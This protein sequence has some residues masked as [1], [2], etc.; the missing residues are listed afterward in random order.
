MIVHP[1]QCCFYA[2]HIKYDKKW[3]M[4]RC[5]IFWDALL[6]V[7]YGGQSWAQIAAVSKQVRLACQTV[8][9]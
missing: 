8:S 2:D 6:F 3:I 5:D 9:D 1:I 7:T 4:I